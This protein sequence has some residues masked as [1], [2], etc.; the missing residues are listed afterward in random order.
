MKNSTRSG[1]V[2]ASGFT[3]SHLVAALALAA[4]APA[5]AGGF[6]QVSGYRGKNDSPFVG[7]QLIVNDFETS[8][9]TVGVL[10]TGTVGRV[11]GT[12]VDSDDASL[13]G[14]G[15]GG[16]S[17]ALGAYLPVFA[18][19][20]A[21]FSYQSKLLGGTPTSVGIVV[22]S[23]NGL[24]DINGIAIDVPVTI[25][26]SLADGSMVS[27]TFPVRSADANATDDVFLGYSSVDG[28]TALSVQAEIP[29]KVDH[30]QLALP[31]QVT[32]P[33]IRSDFDGD[34]KADVCW[35][36][37]SNSSVAIWKMDGATRAETL[38]PE[39]AP[40][41][42][43]VVL[44]SADLNGDQ[45]ADILWQ[46]PS[47]GIVSAWLMDGDAVLESGAIS[48]RLAGAWKFL[49]AGDIDGDGKGD[50]VFRHATTGEVQGWIMQGL[51]RLEVGT[52][53]N[54]A[55]LTALGMGDFD[56]DGK[57]DLLWRDRDRHVIV[58][59]LNGLDLASDQ[60]VANSLNLGSSW[61]VAGTP[62]L[63]GDGSA[64]ILW[65]NGANGALSAW[66]MSGASRTGGGNITP[67][68]SESWK[69]IGTSDYDGD[70]RDD[71][72]WRKG[73][74]GDVYVWLMDGTSRTSSAFVV[75]VG[76]TWT[77]LK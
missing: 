9:D 44:G 26:V 14:L 66:F 12:S 70:G 20:S 52:I 21:T 25:T 10:V 22:T 59:K 27:Q 53:G 74:N 15:A 35:Y 72:M 60:A 6:A 75:N 48:E 34:G 47:T 56:G 7:A 19:G 32:P 68:V 4:A 24:E 57:Q 50:C 23:A 13:D 64:D 30:L 29:I 54:S 77:P 2:V 42:G 55:G 18:P 67:S 17:L 58:W 31:V 28:I 46:K 62:D 49:G 69:V 39:N 73:T 16:H 8:A 71:I 41:Q 61:R 3:R 37:R 36:K 33:S 45:R 40:T 65:R 63:N 5:F 1:V 51:T 76:G 38:T 11:A 43:A